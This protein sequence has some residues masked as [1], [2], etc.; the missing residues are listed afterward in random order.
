VGDA[1]VVARND[2]CSVVPGG[3]KKTRVKRERYTGVLVEAGA[4]PPEER[5]RN[6]SR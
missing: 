1:E 5:L 6:R 4:A 3:L 2:E